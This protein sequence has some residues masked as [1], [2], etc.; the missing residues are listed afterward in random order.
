MKNGA[1]TAPALQLSAKIEEISP[2]AN[3]LHSAY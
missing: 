1:E 3:S 2:Q